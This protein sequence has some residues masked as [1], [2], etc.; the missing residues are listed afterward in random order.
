M[1]HRATELQDKR[2]LLADMLDPLLKQFLEIVQEWHDT[3]L[4]L[5][6]L[7]RQ[8]QS[9]LTSGPP[10]KLVNSVIV[11]ENWISNVDRTLLG[12]SIALTSRDVMEEQIK[13]YTDIEASVNKEEANL[14]DLNNT[15]E[16]LLRAE[17]QQ[18][19]ADSF[20]RQLSKMN[21]C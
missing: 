15:A 9:S 13:K 14:H 19:W 8:L 3:H 18:P 21:K 2:P 11:L 5:E 4:E 10:P 6:E 16:D 7:E 12:D 20:E 1:A 17:Q